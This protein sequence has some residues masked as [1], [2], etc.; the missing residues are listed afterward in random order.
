[1]STGNRSRR[2]TG[3][4]EGK[5]G[6]GGWKVG[7]SSPF[8]QSRPPSIKDNCINLFPI[9]R[10][11]SRS[12]ELITLLNDPAPPTSSGLRLSIKFSSRSRTTRVPLPPS[13]LH[14][15]SLSF[16]PLLNCNLYESRPRKCTGTEEGA[17]SREFLK[18]YYY[19]PAPPSILPVFS[20][21]SMK[22]SDKGKVR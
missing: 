22:T 8:V 14:P 21:R 17:G 20:R 10:R 9:R 15:G 18:N 12:F 16:L 5:R 4:C 6:N 2:V 11:N 1:M 7:T 19:Q 13:S 3:T